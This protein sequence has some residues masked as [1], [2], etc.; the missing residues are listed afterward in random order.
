MRECQSFAQGESDRHARP[1]EDPAGA[2]S[3]AQGRWN[4]TSPTVLPS[5]SLMN[6]CHSS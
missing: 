2:L 1:E 5:E 6:A 4:A 3:D